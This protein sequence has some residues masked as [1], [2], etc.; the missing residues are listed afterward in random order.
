MTFTIYTLA[1]I[2][3]LALSIYGT[4]IAR[5]AALRFQ[6]VDR[7][8]GRLKHQAEPVPYL[9]GLAISLSFLITLAMTFEFSREVLGLLLAGT[10]VVMLGLIDDFGVLTPR[11]K[12]AGQ[13]IAVFVLIKSGVRIE[14]TFLPNW[15]QI[16]L[17]VI[18]MVG[19]INAFNII[20][21]MDGLAGS[22]AFVAT[23]ILFAV[24]LLTHDTDAPVQ[25]AALAG[26]LLGFL[27][28]NWP[29]AKIYMGDAGS[30]FIGFL[31]G[32]VAM[33]LQYTHESVLGLF[34]PVLILGVPIFDTLFVMAIRYLRGIPVFLGSPD[35]FA[36]RLRQWR[37]SAPRIV[38]LSSGATLLLGLAG[39]S[40]LWLP[41]GHALLVVVVTTLVS[42]AAAVWLKGIDM[43]QR[44]R[45]S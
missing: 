18:W 15:V 40:M 4:P 10:I 13:L 21:V 23:L 2:L 28:Y 6:I 39:L 35:H 25:M 31:L 32:A 36:L 1:F 19:M 9:G 14:L 27:Y 26:S 16:G 42:L 20:D 11:A 7:P 43:T 37:L 29:P 3:A 44:R 45:S 38:A 24:A 33:T 41:I 8:D 5:Q 17:T 30:M 12:L 34:A 22:V